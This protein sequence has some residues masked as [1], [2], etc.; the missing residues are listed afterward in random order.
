MFKERKSVE[1]I[2]EGSELRPKFNNEGLI[3]VVTTDITTNKLLMH[4]YMNAEALKLTIE[5]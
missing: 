2:E 3:P 4:A 5:I 1:E